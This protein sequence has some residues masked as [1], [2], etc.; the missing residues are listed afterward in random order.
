V[1]NE[2]L[3][4]H[5]RH[6]LNLRPVYALGRWLLENLPLEAA[7]AITWGTAWIAS[8]A[9]PDIRR[10]IE[11]NVRHVLSR[12]EPG[13]DD[14]ERARRARAIAARVFINRGTWFADLSVLAG[15]RS[16]DG[17]F[18]SEVSGAWLGL[19]E[20]LGS[21]RGAI[22][23]SAHLGNWHGGGVL[24]ARRGLPVRSVLFHNHA[25]D[26]MDRD[27]AR[28]GDLRQTFVDHDPFSMMEIVRALRK[29]ELVAML[30]DKPW[31]SRSIE[32]PFFGRPARF[33][34]GPFRIARLAE[35][36]IFP[37]FCIPLRPRHYR[38]ELC[39]PIEVAGPDPLEAERDAAARFARVLERF[40]APNLDLWFNFTPVWE[41]P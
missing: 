18:R 19:Q 21:G 24:V 25:G 29:G 12:T 5:S 39:E 14:G 8:H 7:Y 41:E 28:R 34:L 13:L 9:S 31:D 32:A 1:R 40:V 27:V 35:V 33:P 15:R 10:A 6:W 23:A 26:F 37:A 16:M 3:W 2:A 4:E 36:P 17:L 20:A 22:L 11:S 38:A 30:A